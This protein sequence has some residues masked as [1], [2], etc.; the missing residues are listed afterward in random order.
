MF[1]TYALYIILSL[2]KQNINILVNL[3]ERKLSYKYGITQ[4]YV[5][6]WYDKFVYGSWIMHTY[7]Q[8]LALQYTVNLET[9]Q[10]SYRISNEQAKITF[11]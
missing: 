5:I 8:Y 2:C 3:V 6:I 11:K 7:N 4:L 9:K 1:A 10:R